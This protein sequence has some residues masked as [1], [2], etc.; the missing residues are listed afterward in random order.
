MKENKQT[1][2]LLILLSL[3]LIVGFSATSWISYRVSRQA[4]R[5]QII[6]DE[7]PLTSDNI[8]SGIQRD[9]L[10]PVF[11]SS[12]MA[13]DSF[14]RNWVI[15][16]EKDHDRLTQF[17]FETQH[18]YNTCTS[19][20]VSE[21]TRLY[22]QSKG[23]LKTVQANDPQDHWYFR[24]RQ[25]PD[26]HEINVDLDQANKY[27]MTIFV[28]HKVFDFN[29]NYIGSTG[30]GLQVSVVRQIIESYHEKF[31]R[32]VYFISPEGKVILATD[33]SEG[34]NIRDLPGLAEA[35]AR[36][37]SA[38]SANLEYKTDNKTFFA[39]SRYIPELNWILL[40]SK[41]DENAFQNIFRSLLLNLAL[42]GLVTVIVIVLVYVII[43]SYRRK[44]KKMFLLELE[45]EGRNSEQKGEID[46]QHRQLIEQ[47]SKLLQLN[48]S[49]DKLF[50]IIAHDLRSPLGNMNQLAAM[51]EESLD[52]GRTTEAME[53]LA[54]Q[55]E[56]SASTLQLLDHLFDWAKSQMSELACVTA[57]FSLPDCLRECL[58]AVEIQAGKK[59]I[60]VSLEC[61]AVLVVNA[62]RNM[63]LTVVRNLVSNAVKFTGNG[64]KIEVS[65]TAEQGT[66][67]VAIKDSGLGIAPER[68]G[69]LFAFVHN[70]STLGTDGERGTG[71]GLALCRELI[72]KNGGEIKVESTPGV[73]SVFSFTLRKSN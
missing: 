13:N 73:G 24:V 71:L 66:V 3:L 57:D 21:K 43:R 58:A 52:A 59:N 36:I 26:D 41:S 2:R 15:S 7:L 18:K 27:A 32:T 39:N 28:N 64:G 35:A 60:A 37:L 8:Y 51:A 17:L 53:Y 56:L 40:V 6:N 23:I 9:I 44:L 63:V 4:L 25:M 45:L 67:T 16:G 65:A 42:C 69:E 72:H 30:V 22:Y 5:N 54:D 48:S 61:P 20:F 31:N 46:R 19:F 29:G 10:Q 33:D 38:D 47:N 50:S 49:K 11:I 1:V 14:L 68:M 62:N 34:K 70:K 12:L 55:R